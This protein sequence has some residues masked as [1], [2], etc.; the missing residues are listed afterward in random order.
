MTSEDEQELRE[1]AAQARE[2]VALILRQP[3]PRPNQPKP[4]RIM[5]LTPDEDAAQKKIESLWK[6]GADLE[7]ITKDIDDY[8]SN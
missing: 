1:L 7:T 4:I 2:V 3:G 8:L 6:I 5:P